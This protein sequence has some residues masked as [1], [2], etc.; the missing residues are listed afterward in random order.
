M[1][2]FKI[3]R[4]DPDPAIIQNAVDILNAGGIIVYPTDTL[5][6]LGVDIANEKAMN[7]LFLLK[8][9]SSAIPVSLMVDNTDKIEESSGLFPLGM[10]QKLNKL[11]PGKFTILL[12]N[13][14]KQKILF[15]THLQQQEKIG[16]RIPDDKF[17]SMLSQTF[18]SPISTTSANVSGKGNAENIAQ[19]LAQFGDKLD[20]V[21]DVGPMH[22]TIGST[23]LDFTKE[24]LMIVREGEVSR[25]KLRELLPGQEIRYKKNKFKIVFVCSGNICRSPMAEGILKAMLA[26]T[27]YKN[28]I[29]VSSA[30]TLN[31]SVSPVH[32]LADMISADNN[33]NI[34]THVSTYIS[35]K[36]IDNADIVISMAVNHVEYLSKKFPQYKNKIILLKEWKRNKQL[37]KPSIADPIGHNSE[38]FSDTFNEILIELKRI[39]PFIFT[40]LKKFMKYHDLHL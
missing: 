33:I 2:Y 18:G 40:E 12:P 11:L 23:I 8:G 19:V 10:H 31:L 3:D 16:W 22:Q 15:S 36:I 34:H 28:L 1:K 38:F 14:M 29:E 30:G 6:G 27:R 4:N 20:L 24:P 39:L 9:R 7:N 35:E 13:K 37:F 25:A 5:Y 21:I 17:C 32:E 26:K